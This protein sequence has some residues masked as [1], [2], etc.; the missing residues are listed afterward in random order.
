MNLLERCVVTKEFCDRT[1][2]YN[3]NVGGDGGWSYVNETYDH[4]KRVHNGKRW[5]Q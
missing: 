3:I 1:D 4:D 2:T 5:I